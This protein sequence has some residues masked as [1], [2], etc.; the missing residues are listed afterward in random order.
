MHMKALAV[1]LPLLLH[2]VSSFVIPPAGESRA[3]QENEIHSKWGNV[4]VNC[5][6]HKVEQHIKPIKSE[7]IEGDSEIG[8][9]Y[10]ALNARKP[11]K[12]N[13]SKSSDKKTSRPADQKT[14]SGDT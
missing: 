8:I 2:P 12:K 4:P 7:A 3:C 6:P 1:L 10:H 13:P 14:T 11:A 9:Q 5:G